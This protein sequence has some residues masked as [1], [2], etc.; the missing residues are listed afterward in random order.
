MYPE[1]VRN[2]LPQRRTGKEYVRHIRRVSF[3]QPGSRPRSG[4]THHPPPGPSRP[5]RL[6]L[7][8]PGSDRPRT[9]TAEDHGPGGSFR[10]TDDR[11]RSRPGHGVQWRHLQLPRTAWRTGKPWLSVLLR[12]RH[13]SSLE[14]YHAWGADLLPRLNGM[15][16][17]AVWE[18]DRQRLFLAR[19][20]LG[21]KPL[22]YSL[23]RSRLRF[24]RACRPCSRAATSPATSIRR[25]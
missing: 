5:R 2:P 16:A 9:S 4:R 13:R 7:P 11:S 20:R 8:R 10:P 19:D 3:R 17:F 12:R 22:Y 15:F 21:I 23:D 18:R 14:G 6:G 1:G 25:R 24:A